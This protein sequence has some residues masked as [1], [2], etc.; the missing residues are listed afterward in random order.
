MARETGAVLFA[1]GAF[2]GSASQASPAGS[3]RIPGYSDS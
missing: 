2:H 1:H 3:L